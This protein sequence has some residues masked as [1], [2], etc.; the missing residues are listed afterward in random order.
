MPK[1][2]AKTRNK[3][4]IATNI[5]NK[6]RFQIRRKLDRCGPLGR[7]RTGTWAPSAPHYLSS[8]HLQSL[9]LHLPTNHDHVPCHGLCRSQSLQICSIY[10]CP[11]LLLVMHKARLIW[12]YSKYFGLEGLSIF[13]KNTI[14]LEI[15]LS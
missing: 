7:P 2:I 8:V 12:P 13:S 6:D 10:G 4:S 5:K 9:R 11:I 1:K 14:F 15:P 3:H